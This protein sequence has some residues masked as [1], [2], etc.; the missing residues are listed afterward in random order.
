MLFSHNPSIPASQVQQQLKFTDKICIW[1]VL[2]AFSNKGSG[3]K[4]KQNVSYEAK[5]GLY[6]AAHTRKSFYGGF[7]K[8]EIVI[9]FT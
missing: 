6:S 4:I 2:I 7:N 1:R 3:V 5:L 8:K 9:F